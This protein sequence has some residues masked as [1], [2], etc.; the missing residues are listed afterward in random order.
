MT[1]EG[2]KNIITDLFNLKDI[3]IVIFSIVLEDRNLG[4]CICVYESKY[5]NNDIEKLIKRKTNRIDGKLIDPWQLWR[6]S[7]YF[8]SLSEFKST[9]SKKDN[10]L[11]VQRW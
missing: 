9:F 5:R 11:T 8:N 1:T 6:C 3:K 4:S 2:L 10:V 7:Q